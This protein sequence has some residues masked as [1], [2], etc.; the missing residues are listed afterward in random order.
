M[1]ELE[2][3]IEYTFKNKELLKKALTHSSYANEKGYGRGACNERLEFLGDSLLG[4]ITASHLYKKYPDKPEGEMTRLRAEL[5]CEASLVR[6]S[7][8]LRLGGWLR[9]GRGEE[10]GNGRKRPSIL[11]D[12]FEALLAAIYLDGGEAAARE[13]VRKYVLGGHRDSDSSVSDYK[14]ALQELVQK[15]GGEAPL[16]RLTGESGPDHLKLFTAE[17]LVNG[18]VAGEGNGR[19]KKEAEQAAARCAFEKLIRK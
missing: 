9:L 5:V 19:S 17:V 13:L 11:A 3:K 4:F 2:E 8:E 1:T 15:S 7:E 10:L 14:T 18:E 6:A 12:A 16:Y